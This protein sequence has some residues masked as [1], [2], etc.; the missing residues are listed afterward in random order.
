MATPETPL[1]TLQDWLDFLA[2]DW[3]SANRPPGW[4]EGTPERIGQLAGEL[5]LS[6]PAPH[7]FIVAGTNGKGSTCTA[8]AEFAMAQGCPW[9]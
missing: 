1:L 9:A 2:V 7:L 6:V 8:L 5:G 4:F 3:M